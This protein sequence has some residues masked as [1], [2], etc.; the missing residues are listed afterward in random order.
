M[1]GNMG[2][3]DATITIN[4]QTIKL[5][6]GA[7]GPQSSQHPALDLPPGKYKYTTK[8]G[9]HAKSGQIDLE[10]DDAWGLMLGPDGDVLALQAY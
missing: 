6:A 7:G 2:Q 5:A 10:A 4:K 8:V 9:G 3:S 1:L